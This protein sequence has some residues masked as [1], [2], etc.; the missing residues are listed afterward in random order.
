MILRQLCFGNFSKNF[1]IGSI[2][3]IGLNRCVHRF[4]VDLVEK[5]YCKMDFGFIGKL[6]SALMS[7]RMVEALYFLSV[8]N[9][10]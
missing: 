10:P 8:N 3:K 5:H 6:V 4:S 7:I 2:K 9:K 1:T